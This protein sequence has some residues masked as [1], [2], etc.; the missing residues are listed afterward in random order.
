MAIHEPTLNPDADTKKI[1]LAFLKLAAEDIQR[2]YKIR[3][4]YITIGRR[5][6][7]TWKQMGEALNIPP[8]TLRMRT[9]RQE[10]GV[11]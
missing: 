1:A 5:E 6:G 8:D 3:D 7:L 4:Y 9:R 11:N 10:T 2:A